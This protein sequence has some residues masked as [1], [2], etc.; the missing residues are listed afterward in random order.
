MT[1]FQ[2]TASALRIRALPGGEDTGK[3]ILHGQVVEAA[4]ASWDEQWYYV[5]APA[6]EGWASSSFLEPVPDEEEFVRDPDWPEV[7]HGLVQLRE[8]F[9]EAGRPACSSGSVFLPAALPLAWGGQI[10][11]FACHELMEGPFEAVF[12]EIY[13]R[14]LWELLEDFGGCYNHR[15][16]R[17]LQK[18]STHSWGIAVDL[19]VSSNPLGR[20]PKMDPQIVAIFEDVGFTWGGRWSR[21]DGMHF[22]WATGY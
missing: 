19:N 12:A 3:R 17:G 22:Q 15:R 10:S 6:G 7:P 13:R 21:P 14:D 4:G 1:L 11:R 2:C 20:A 16:A 5:V 8:V 18:L 9:G